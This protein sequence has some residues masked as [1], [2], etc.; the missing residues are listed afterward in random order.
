MQLVIA[1]R[2]SGAFE[3]QNVDRYIENGVLMNITDYLHTFY[4]VYTQRQ[5]EMDLPEIEATHLLEE[6][7]PKLP[8]WPGK[9]LSLKDRIELRLEELSHDNCSED[10]FFARDI[11]ILYRQTYFEHRLLN[12]YD[13]RFLSLF[14]VL[15]AYVGAKYRF[16]STPDTIQRLAECAVDLWLVSK[17]YRD[18]V[19]GDRLP[20]IAAAAR[21]L[22]RLSGQPAT[23]ENGKIVLR[24]EFLAPVHAE[25][26]RRMEIAGGMQFLK[27]LFKN[28]LG[29]CFDAQLDRYMIHRQS[30]SSYVPDK[31]PVL[32]TPFGYLF[33]LAVKHL[34][35]PAVDIRL[36]Q[37]KGYKELVQMAEDVLLVFDVSKSYSMSLALVSVQELPEYIVDNSVLDVLCLPPQY[38]PGFC[39]MVIDMYKEKCLE[40][41]PELSCLKSIMCACLERP[42]CAVFSD[43]EIAQKVKLPLEKVQGILTLFSFPWNQV[44]QDYHLPLDLVNMWD[45]PMIQTRDPHRFFLLSPHFS[46]YAFCRRLEDLLVERD[47]ALPK[48]LGKCVEKLADQM[49]CDRGIP[50]YS[51]G[52]YQEGCGKNASRIEFDFILEDKDNILFL[53]VKKRSLGDGFHQARDIDIF[54]DLAK[55]MLD[56]QVQAYRRRLALTANGSLPLYHRASDI[57]PY[58]VLKLNGRKIHTMSICL[59][60]YAFFTQAFLAQKFVQALLVGT[61]HTVDPAQE[62]KLAKLNQLADELRNLSAPYLSIDYLRNFTYNSY[63]RSLQQLWVVLRLCKDDELVIKR[64]TWDRSVVFGSMD[65]YD[66]FRYVHRRSLIH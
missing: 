24:D 33:Q 37:G 46:G 39:L 65:F 26:E 10:A 32:E 13:N 50:H 43:Q 20:E 58:A 66:G 62:S 30:R 35:P 27:L 4:E 25:L 2:V 7:Y 34:F 57:E 36:R 16:L 23:V 45:R 44:N 14:S 47:P 40:L 9:I 60:E 19:L 54:F 6:R 42:S 8:P 38:A 15:N 41:I 49:L 61:F 22:S 3:A 59:P 18:D 56:D 51:C 29:P 17:S 55:G 53:E 63:F 21:R 12:K 48:K 64:L 1:Y 28:E 52:Y 11:R 5:Q 31:V